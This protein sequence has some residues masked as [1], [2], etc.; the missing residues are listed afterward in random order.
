MHTRAY[1]IQ[2]LINKFNYKSYL[3]I[4]CQ[5]DWNFNQIKVDHKVGVD[6]DSGGTHR[7]TSDEYF[8]KHNDKFD[9][10]FIDGLHHA[11]QVD[12]DIE[13][14]L[15]IL[16]HNGTIVMHDCNPYDKFAQEIPLTPQHHFWNGDVWKSFVKVRKN[17]HL[18]SLASDFD[19]GC[20]VLRVRPNSSLLVSDEELTYEN[21]VKNKQS[22]LRLTNFNNVMS[23]A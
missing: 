21:L 4:G 18:D 14:A 15:K 8:E 5:T 12:K 13:N 3:E 23:W 16:N 7:M 10:I 6:P 2:S 20:G 22:W 11:D 1:L 9:I 17:P 19:H